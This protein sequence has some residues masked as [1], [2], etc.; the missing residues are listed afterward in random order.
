M[1]G[2]LDRLLYGL[3]WVIL[4]AGLVVAAMVAIPFLILLALFLIPVLVV[5]GL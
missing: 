3:V 5:F 2:L 4:I 1:S